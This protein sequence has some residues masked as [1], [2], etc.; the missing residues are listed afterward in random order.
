MLYFIPRYF[1]NND[2]DFPLSGAQFLLYHLRKRF[3]KVRY[4]TTKF[5]FLHVFM[6]F[7]NS[8]F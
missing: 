7:L 6:I 3:Q 4:G 1:C 8:L 2:S 5:Q